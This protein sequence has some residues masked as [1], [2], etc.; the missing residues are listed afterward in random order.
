[1]AR[2]NAQI[3]ATVSDDLNVLTF[4]VEGF[5]PIAIVMA[6]LQP[7]IRSRA[8]VHGI[9]QKIGDAAA[10]GK[11]ASL[12]DKHAAMQAMATRLMEGDWNKR[13][14]DGT[15]VQ[16]GIIYRAFRQWVADKAKKA[17][18]PVPADDAIRASYDKLDRKGQLALRNNA[19]IAAI[20]DQMRAEQTKT[21]VDTSALLGELGL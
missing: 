12:S 2:K 1:M 9:G 10:L 3:A 13:A 8:V 16:P 11:D 4:T 20:M 6:D 14:G 5:D 18:K 17:K 15:A 7:D 19:E 21:E